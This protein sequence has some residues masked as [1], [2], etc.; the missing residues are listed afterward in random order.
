MPLSAQVAESG[1][2]RAWPL[3]IADWAGGSR[4]WGGQPDPR[5]AT[6]TLV[7]ST[8]PPCPLYRQRPGAQF[9]LGRVTV[10]EVSWPRGLPPELWT[11]GGELRAGQESPPS[12]GAWHA[13]VFWLFVLCPPALPTADL[14][15]EGE[16]LNISFPRQRKGTWASQN[17]S[18]SLVALPGAVN[19]GQDRRRAW[20]HGSPQPQVTHEV[21]VSGTPHARTL[22]HQ[23][24]PETDSGKIRSSP[25]LTPA[26]TQTSLTRLTSK[27]L[28]GLFSNLS[29]PL[30][31]E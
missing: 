23:P 24:Q 19:S 4:G 26:Y 25:Q 3:P 2:D 20:E 28:D 6:K 16:Q 30:Y 15:V 7:L 21:R 9:S 14:N 29:P 11:L 22:R 8:G 12:W 13:D 27:H 18:H 17:W 10:D 31:C 1:G 5:F